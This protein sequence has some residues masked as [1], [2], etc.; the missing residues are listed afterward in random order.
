MERGKQR[1][2][3]AT[4]REAAIVALLVIGYLIPRLHRE[5]V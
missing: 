2:E 4:A 5:M 3:S 1:Y